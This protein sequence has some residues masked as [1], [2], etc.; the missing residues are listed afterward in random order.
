MIQLPIGD[1]EFGIGVFG[2]GNCE[3]RIEDWGKINMGKT[4][5]PNSK[6]PIVF[7]I[8]PIGDFHF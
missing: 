5:I 7:F 3:F 1:Y 6:S 4:P 8:S 2:I